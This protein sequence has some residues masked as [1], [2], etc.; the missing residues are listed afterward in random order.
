M[1]I[2]MNHTIRKNRITFIIIGICELY[3]FLIQISINYFKNYTLAKSGLLIS[4]NKTREL[5]IFDRFEF[6]NE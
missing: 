6:R 3:F 1:E 5:G 4:G 2:K